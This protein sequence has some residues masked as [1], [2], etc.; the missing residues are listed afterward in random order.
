MHIHS[1][2]QRGAALLLP[3]AVLMSSCGTKKDDPMPPPKPAMTFQM[4]RDVPEFSGERTFE[5]LKKQVA[6]G[7]RVPN[8]PAHAA[9]LNWMVDFLRPLADTVRVQ[10]F[11]MGGYD[12]ITLR[13]SNV[14]ASFKPDAKERVLLCAHWDSRPR[15]DRE[16]DSS[17]QRIAIPGANDGASGVAVLLHLAEVFAR[18]CPT[19]GVDLVFFDGEDYGREGDESMYCLGSKYFAATVPE[20]YAP[21]YGVLLDLVGDK[22][23][24]FPQEEFSV[25]YAGDIVRMV[26]SAAGQLGVP[27][28]KVQGYGGIIDDHHA[29]NTTAGIRTIDII[30]AE[31]VGHAAADPRRKYWHTLADTPEQCSPLTLGRVGKVLLHVLLGTKPV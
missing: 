8:T 30:D 16:K 21:L 11:S 7:P 24:V 1:T 28:F 13:M 4:P 2:M 14:I 26:W 29:L 5:L 3:I 15:A 19:V 25:Q 6:F 10:E 20:G 12:G 18:I 31:L 27:N 9:C 22:D 17:R 23:A